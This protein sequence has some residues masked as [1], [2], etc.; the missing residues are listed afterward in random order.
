MIKAKT[1]IDID[2]GDR[3]KLLS[4]FKHN[5]ASMKDNDSF[6]KHNTVIA[7]YPNQHLIEYHQCHFG[8]K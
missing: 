5:R 6:K 4:L 7:S 1:D 8:N 3:D 2:T